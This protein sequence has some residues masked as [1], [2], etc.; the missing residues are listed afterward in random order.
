[1]IEGISL[2][3]KEKTLYSL[4]FVFANG[5]EF[6]FIVFF[7]LCYLLLMLAN[8]IR[9]SR[10]FLVEIAAVWGMICLFLCGGVFFF[11]TWVPFVAWEENENK[12]EMC[13]QNVR[14]GVFCDGLQWIQIGALSFLLGTLVLQPLQLFHLHLTLPLSD[15]QQPEL[16]EEGEEEREGEVEV[17]VEGEEKG[18]EKSLSIQ[19]L[20]QELTFFSEQ[21]ALDEE[22]R[23][24]NR[25]RASTMITFRFVHVFLLLLQLFD[26]FPLSLAIYRQ[27]NRPIERNYEIGVGLFLVWCYFL[28]LCRL[29]VSALLLVDHSHRLLNFLG[30]TLLEMLSIFSLGVLS[31]VGGGCHLLIAPEA[32]NLCSSNN[33]ILFPA[34]ILFVLL[35]VDHA[36]GLVS[37][38]Y[39]ASSSRIQYSVV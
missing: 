36:L 18:E 28:I 32:E 16:G 2:S 20:V 29:F 30:L 31:F 7:M 10:V 26:Y 33:W 12:N 3:Q 13:S 24:Q 4:T 21:V 39:G 8:I 22:K 35:A 37:V 25:F 9:K 11:A 17:E 19:P 1:M 15:G 14:Y 23:D 5:I 6:Y 34:V 27:V 38:G